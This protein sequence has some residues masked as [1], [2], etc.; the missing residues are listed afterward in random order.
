MLAWFWLAISASA[1]WGLTYVASQYI[2][3][4]LSP[5]HILW[6]SSLVIF[7]GLGLFF[8]I[9]GHGKSLFAKLN[10]QHP[11]L[12]FT[13]IAY[14]MLYF[15]ASVLILKSINFGNASLAALVESAY[16]LFTL[17]FAYVFLKQVQFNWGILLG[18]GFLLT[19]LIL[20]QVFSSSVLK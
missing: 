11:K 4:S 6:L 17:I 16:P 15:L 14:A 18:C 12:I 9:T 5:L 7:V 1:L 2:L 3:K 13:V 19:G 8:L 10:L 20:I